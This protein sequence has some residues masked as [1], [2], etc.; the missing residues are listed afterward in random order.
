[1]LDMKLYYM[2]LY[3]NVYVQIYTN[4]YMY[5]SLLATVYL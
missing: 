5:M 2:D 3:G 1:M 4:Q